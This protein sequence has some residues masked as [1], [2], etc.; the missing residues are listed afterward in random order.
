METFH[1]FPLLLESASMP[2][3]SWFG[4]C[5]DRVDKACTLLLSLEVW[6]KI[7]KCTSCEQKYQIYDPTLKT[8]NSNK[9][10]GVTISNA[11]SKKMVLKTTRMDKGH[12][13]NG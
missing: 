4:S 1:V 3:D 5:R 10:M 13:Q 7:L 11:C 6:I 9:Q 12:R 2:P 8:W